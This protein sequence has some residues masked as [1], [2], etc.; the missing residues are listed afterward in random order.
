MSALEQLLFGGR[1]STAV[2]DLD[3]VV[4]STSPYRVQC[5]GE[6]EPGEVIPLVAKAAAGQRVAI[7]AIGRRR[8]AIPAVGATP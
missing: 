1:N 5:T 6:D 8:Y 7:L 3:G 4:T 2:T